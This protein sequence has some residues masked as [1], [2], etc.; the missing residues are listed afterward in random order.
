MDE[1]I[2]KNQVSDE[3]AEVRLKELQDKTDHSD[4]E[5]QEFET[6]KTEKT[7]RFQKRI[8]QLTWKAKEA[9]E[10]FGK[11]SSEVDDLRRK[12]EELETKQVK[13]AVRPTQETVQV[14]NQQFY[15]DD[16]LL[17]MIETGELTQNKAYELQ[18][19]RE[20]AVIKDDLRN[21]FKQENEKQ[22]EQQSRKKDADVVLKAHPEFSKD[23][24]KYDP[25]N[26]LLKL[27][28]ELYEEG[29]KHDPSGLSRAMRRAEQ[30]LG[31]KNVNLDLSDNLNLSRPS[32]PESRSEKSEEI[33]I[34]QD[35]EEIA[36]RM[37]CR[38]DSINR[39]TGR[40]YTRD[41]AIAKYK[42]AKAL[43]G[44]R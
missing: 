10:R 31:G 35:E 25:N 20:R 11:A 38:G 44:G 16:T 2:T 27:T 17:A 13:P 26:P 33:K 41:E 3:E 22:T 19:Q 36:V 32:A 6:L 40:P 42:R 8:D 4:E 28:S 21:E 43:R 37:H 30:I 34:T 12:V 15:S 1:T 24:Y 39:K 23:H 5:K 9:E 18:R 29:Y 7:T 14:G